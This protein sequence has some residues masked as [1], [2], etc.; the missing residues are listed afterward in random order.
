MQEEDNPMKIEDAWGVSVVL[1]HA[2]QIKT[3]TDFPGRVTR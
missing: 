3:K 1:S 2:H